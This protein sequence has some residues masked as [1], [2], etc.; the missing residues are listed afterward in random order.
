[1]YFPMT[2]SL[3]AVDSEMLATEI[4]MNKCM[5]DKDCTVILVL[6]P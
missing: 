2:L 4:Q 3:L 6:C 5:F 1:M